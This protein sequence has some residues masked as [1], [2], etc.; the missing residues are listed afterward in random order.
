MTPMQRALELA[1]HALGAASP[2]PSVGAVLV[3]DG[4]IVGEGVTQPAGGPH[5]EAVAIAQAGDRARGAALYVTLEP[6]NYHGRT[7]PCVPAIIDA[8]VAQ[9]HAAT[10][11]PNPRVDGRGVADLQAAGVRVAVGEEAAA[12]QRLMERHFRWITTGM[13]FVVAKYAMSLDGKI[14]TA[15]G[16]SRWVSGAAS[17]RRVHR[18]RST[19][20]AIMVGVGTVLR[21]DP[22]LTARDEDDRPMDRQ[23]L[24]VVVDSRG[25]LPDT[26]RLLTAPGRTL[27]ATA[28]AP[29]QREAA[30]RDAGAEVAAFPA[31]DGRVDLR[32]LMARLGAREVTG[33]LV[34]GGGTLLASLFREEL[35]DKVCAFVAPV[36]IGGRDAPTPWDGAGARAVADALRLE[37]VTVE[38]LEDDLMVV[39]Y[40]ARR[41]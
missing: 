2:N 37:R 22:Q 38:R 26:A 35:V 32:S 16:D 30:L 41:R 39:G 28:D 33:L 17:R 8:G 40:P 34:E 36:L 6:C 5:A 24:R 18:M 29:P 9:V 7:P 1:R 4:R 20:D 27:V 11:D 3:R 14:A 10:L 19:C 31:A 21:D 15:A 12:A 23:P 13:P 25:R